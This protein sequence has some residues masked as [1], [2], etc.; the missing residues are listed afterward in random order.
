M[1]G[2]MASRKQVTIDAYNE[3]ME[4]L[5]ADPH[6]K[7]FI[8]SIA[9]FNSNIGRERVITAQPIGNV[10]GLTSE[11]YMPDGATPLYD[12]I[13]DSVEEI[14]DHKG[15]VLFIIQ[16]DGQE[17]SSQRFSKRNIIDKIAEK[18]KEN[19][20]FVYLGCDIDAMGEAQ[21][22]GIPAGSTMSYTGAQTASV[23]RVT[24]AATVSYAHRGSMPTAD[25]Y[26]GDNTLDDIGKK[27]AEAEETNLLQKKLQTK[28][29]TGKT[30]N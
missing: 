24:A 12:A 6:T 29:N 18:T 25:F 16:T 10:V 15:P 4:G 20:Q 28:K 14:K 19:W 7:D 8:L 1:S 13:G 5:K 2:S 21:K 11:R 27:A 26:T 17:N 3:Y 9:L 30:K 22:I 23:M